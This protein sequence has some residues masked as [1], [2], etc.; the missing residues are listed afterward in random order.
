MKNEVFLSDAHQCTWAATTNW[1]GGEKKNVEID[2]LQ[3]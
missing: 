3:L 2:L 1:K